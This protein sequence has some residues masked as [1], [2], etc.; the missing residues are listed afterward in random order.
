MKWRCKQCGKLFRP[1]NVG[2]LRCPSGHAYVEPLLES[3]FGEWR[4]TA[5]SP[6]PPLL[7]A[8]G[9]VLLVVFLLFLRS[10]G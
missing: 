7:L 2:V 10:C 9:A 1:A 3:S 5:G 6:I 4:D 8:T